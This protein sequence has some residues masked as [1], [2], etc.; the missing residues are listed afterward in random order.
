MRINT[1]IHKLTMDQAYLIVNETVEWCKDYF[2][3]PVIN[4]R[5]QL[6]VM[7]HSTEEKMVYGEYCDKN[8]WLTINLFHCHNV[9]DIVSTTIHEYVHYTQDLKW[10][11]LYS[12]KMGYDNNPFEVEAR[13]EEK[14]NY[15]KCWK[16]IRKEIL[17]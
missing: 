10:Y 3:P 4:R 14:R 17:I 8:N 11:A 5:K 12:R 15:M 6:C 13:Q 2:E 9:K 1:P 7:I 16:E